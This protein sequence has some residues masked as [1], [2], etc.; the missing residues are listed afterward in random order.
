[1][2][3]LKVWLCKKALLLLQMEKEIEDEV[4]NILNR[5]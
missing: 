5:K 1:V 3:E 4:L 2:E